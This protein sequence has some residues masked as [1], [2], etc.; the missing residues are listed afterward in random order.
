MRRK[1]E[2]FYPQNTSGGKKGIMHLYFLSLYQ[3]P[4]M[5]GG[6]FRNN[7]NSVFE[8]EGIINTQW[9][10]QTPFHYRNRGCGR[11]SFF[12]GSFHH[13]IQRGRRV[14]DQTENDDRIISIK[15]EATN[16][17]AVALLH[18]LFA[19]SP[20]FLSS[21]HTTTIDFFLFSELEDWQG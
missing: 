21:S 11:D 15:R 4:V 8:S 16:H 19:S 2:V 9:E 3:A 10:H 20:S 18:S 17:H 14:I 7:P 5:L 13:I 6:G 12:V 1:R